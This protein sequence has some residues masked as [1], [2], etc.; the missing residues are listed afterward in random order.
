[1]VHDLS[2]QVQAPAR[3]VGAR[4]AVAGL[5][6]PE[7]GEARVREAFPAVHGA[8]AK[9]GQ[10]LVRSVFLAPLGWAI[11]GPLFALK[12]APFVCTRYTITNRR[13]MIQRGLRPKMKQ[14]VALKDIDEVRHDTASS[15]TFYHCGDLEVISGGKVVMRLPA[16]PEPEGFRQAI[17]NAVKAWAPEKANGPFVPASAKT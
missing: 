15:D 9:L 5:M 1:M 17:I 12:Y 11:L 2:Q 13:V 8:P 16:V 4:Q 14:E 10:K 6:P 3:S 7:L